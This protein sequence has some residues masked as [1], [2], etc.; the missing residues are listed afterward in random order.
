MQSEPIIK[1]L[2][3]K[4]EFLAFADV[5]VSP[6]CGYND[7]QARAFVKTVMTI[8]NPEDDYSMDLANSAARHVFAKTEAFE[9]AFRDYAGMQTFAHTVLPNVIEA[10]REV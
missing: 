8:A 3:S 2:P 9:Q 4:K 10:E 7:E 1:P 5:L 6:E